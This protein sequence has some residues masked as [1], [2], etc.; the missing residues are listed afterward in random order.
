[1]SMFKQRFILEV[2]GSEERIYRFECESTSPMGEIHDA[3]YA[4][5]GAIINRMNESQK[6]EEKKEENTPDDNS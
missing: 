2:K 5:K 6:A 1:M 4:M 3:L